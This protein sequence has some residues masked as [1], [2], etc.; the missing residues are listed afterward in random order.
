[1][2]V[3]HY[4]EIDGLALGQIL[5]SGSKVMLGPAV[6]DNYSVCLYLNDLKRRALI[7]NTGLEHFEINESKIRYSSR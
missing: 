7:Q 3:R 6:R 2:E 1:M 4:Y 5:S